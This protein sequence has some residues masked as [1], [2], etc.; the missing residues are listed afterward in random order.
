MSDGKVSILSK[1][2]V[3]F[4]E[5]NLEKQFSKERHRKTPSQEN[6]TRIFKPHDANWA[7]TKCK[8]GH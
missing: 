8:G 6:S 1:R 2:E 4:R 7:R 3:K 5:R